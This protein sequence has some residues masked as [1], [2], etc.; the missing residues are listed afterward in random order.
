MSQKPRKSS[1]VVDTSVLVA[2]VAGMK[3]SI[4]ETN[5]ASAIFVRRW[6]ERLRYHFVSND[7]PST[8]FDINQLRVV[9]A[10]RRHGPMEQEG[11]R[12]YQTEPVAS[13]ALS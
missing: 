12:W 13:G 6:E 9:V 1:G 5:V 2:G 10:L 4:R 8:P 11:T 7:V 3:D